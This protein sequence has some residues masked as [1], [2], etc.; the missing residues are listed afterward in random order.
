MVKIVIQEVYTGPQQ[1]YSNEGEQAKKWIE[2]PLKSPCHCKA[3]GYIDHIG[4][5]E[6]RPYGPEPIC[7]GQR[8]FT[9]FAPHKVTQGGVV[10]F[11]LPQTPNK[12]FPRAF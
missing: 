11:W 8:T 6:S 7:K 12:P 5:E 1:Q 2:H 3:G 4:Y 9:P 10:F